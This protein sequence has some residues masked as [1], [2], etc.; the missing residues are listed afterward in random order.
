MGYWF[1][2]IWKKYAHAKNANTWKK[3]FV[4]YM[5]V[6]MYMYD[7]TYIWLQAFQF[8]AELKMRWKFYWSYSS[9]WN[10]FIVYLG[11]HIIFKWG[12][13]FLFFTSIAHGVL[14]KFLMFILVYGHIFPCVRTFLV[15]CTLFFTLS[16]HFHAFTQTHKHFIYITY[17]NYFD[18]S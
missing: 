18:F 8:S 13:L 15:T 5:Y 10:T 9:L 4:I 6:Y 11:G 17:S 12:G 16:I 3:K 14:N 7:N 1:I 2:C